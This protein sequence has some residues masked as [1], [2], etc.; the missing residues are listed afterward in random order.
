MKVNFIIP[1]TRLSGGIRV[2]FLYANYLT[3]QGDDVICYVPMISYPGKG[4][5]FLYRLKA[6]LGNSLRRQRWFENR[7]TIK[8]V[9]KINN[10]FI[11]DADVT[12][13][14][15][16]Q[17]AEDVSELN[18][19]KGKKFYFIQGYEIYN[20]SRRRVDHSY[21]LNLNMITVSQEL[22]NIIKR[23]SGISP[24]LVHN[25]LSDSEYVSSLF[26]KSNFNNKTILMMDHPEVS[27]GSEE[28][29]AIIKKIKEEFP[30]IKAIAFG[31]KITHNYPDFF[32]LYESP[33]REQ[34][35]KLYKRSGIYLFTSKFDSWGL[36]S[37]EAMAGKCAVVGREIGALAELYNGNNCY[38]VN[39]QQEMY[40]AVKELLK[41]PLKQK[42]IQENGFNSVKNLHWNNS[43]QK[44]RKIIQSPNKS[45]GNKSR[46]NYH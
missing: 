26:S 10:K 31:R 35:F 46:C 9:P 20:G 41:D 29:I 42:Q 24:Q 43:Y 17:T 39:T 25:G 23:I 19:D 11:R 12:I 36:T 14:T 16:W 13:A 5:S 3:S 45:C 28:G 38:L 40:L 4:Q 21:K 30:T 34:L 22:Q 32:E 18:K 7:F 33:S 44:F 15:A 8:L 27:K 37:V 2:I 1:F 6:S